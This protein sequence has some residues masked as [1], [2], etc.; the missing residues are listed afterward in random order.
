MTITLIQALS[1]LASLTLSTPPPAISLD[2]GGLVGAA[3]GS[4]QCNCRARGKGRESS[5]PAA[6]PSLLTSSSPLALSLSLPGARTRASPPR[7][8]PWEEA[9]PG[10]LQKSWCP[11]ELRLW[12]CPRSLVR[13]V[14]RICWVAQTACPLYVL[15]WAWG[16]CSILSNALSEEVF[17]I[18]F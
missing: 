17:Q 4:H 13:S 7:S 10:T 14:S 6:V 12:A 2:V 15:R 18:G 1:L 3:R 16:F 9:A 5:A 11:P 8:L